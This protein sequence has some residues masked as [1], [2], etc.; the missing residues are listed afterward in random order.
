MAKTPLSGLFGRTTQQPAQ[1]KAPPPAAA[2]NGSA[3]GGDLVKDTTTQGFM[4]DVIE[5]SKTVPVL[6]DFWAPWCGPCKQLTPILEKVVRSFKGAVRLVK[7]NIDEHPV[8]AGQM[9]VQSIPAVFAFK[10]GRPV[11]GFM[12][13]QPESQVKAFIER[14]TGKGSGAAD[15]IAAVLQ[16]ANKAL[17]EGSLQ[18]AA[19]IY[20]AILGEDKENIDALAGLAKC[21]L[22]TG[23]L[24]RAEET[25]GLAPPAKQTSTPIAGARAMLE[26]AR[27][28]PGAKEEAKLAE[29][30]KANPAD[31]QA[32]FDLALASNAAGKKAEALEQLLE[33]MRR[34]RTWN[35]DA[36]RKQLVQFF[37]AW[38]P[39][40][41]MTLAG[42]RQL[43]LLLFS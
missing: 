41:E 32:R 42:R 6:V 37:E 9:G 29:R 39:K 31:Y 27:K 4:K 19:Q 21:Y 33:I 34:N 17:E 25:L 20:A 12:G 5:A 26:L 35:E 2:G 30:I 28:T 3:G 38:G 7:M 43:S 18:D 11:D 10:G 23:D 8:I 36:A 14:I 22:R 40:D 16:S 13:A 15:D 24:A 1:P